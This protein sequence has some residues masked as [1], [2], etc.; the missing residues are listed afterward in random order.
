MRARAVAIALF[1]VFARRADAQ[2]ISAGAQYAFAEYAEQGATLHFDGTGSSGYVSLGWR[3]FDISY[4]GAH[5][6]FVPTTAGSVAEPFDITQSDFTLRVRA[7][8]LFSV[9]AGF[10]DREVKPLNAAQSVGAIRLGALMAIPLAAGADVAVRASYLAGSKFSGG[11]S[12]P[13]GVA[14]GLGVSYAPWWERVRVTGD[15]EFLRLDRSITRTEGHV[16][17]PIQS[18]T[19]RLGVMLAY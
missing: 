13:F 8:R 19:A 3:R 4:S 12:A 15:L 17:A 11:G 10:L 14:L 5:L 16:P 1:V 18:S 9:E 7:T 2:R 6:S